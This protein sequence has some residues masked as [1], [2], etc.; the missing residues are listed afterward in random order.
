MTREE[1]LLKEE[2]ELAMQEPP[3]ELIEFL[4]HNK[5][6]FS[7]YVKSVTNS[8]PAQFEPKFQ[9]LVRNIYHRLRKF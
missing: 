9:K 3:K 5:L 7:D 2:Q 4:D 6:S 8:N 1:A